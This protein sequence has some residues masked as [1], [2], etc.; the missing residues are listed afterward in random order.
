MKKFFPFLLT[1]VIFPLVAVDR[2][3]LDSPREVLIPCRQNRDWKIPA[4]Q[5]NGRVIVS[6]EHRLDFPRLGGWAPCWQIFV[7]DQP[8]SSMATRNH[9]RL[10]NKPRSASHLDHGTYK[11][12][13]GE[14]WYSLYSPDY[15][16][17]KKRF[18]PADP[19][20]YRVAL[21]ITGLLRRDRENVVKIRFGSE[22][23][24]YYKKMNVKCPPALGVRNFKVVQE[25]RPSPIPPVRKESEYVHLKNV[26]P[27]DYGLVLREK[28]LIVNFGKLSVPV[29]SYFSAPGAKWYEM[30]GE[31][32]L[33]TPFYAVMRKIVQQ[34]NRI[35]VFDT[36]ISKSDR[37]IGLKIR[38][39]IP[40]GNFDPVYLAG[41]PSP[42][43]EENAGGR[44]P[45]VFLSAPTLEQ[46]IALIAQDDVFRV[47]NLQYCKDGK[48]GIRTETFALSPG[49]SRTVE[50]SIYPVM[51]SD[52]FDFVN[53]VR[54]DWDVNFLIDGGF[55]LS[56]NVF[57]HWTPEEAR[58]FHRNA[59]LKYN[60]LGVFYWGHLGG[61]YA[62]R[63]CA[64]QGSSFID[65]E[66]RGSLAPNTI[67]NFKNEPMRQFVREMLAKAGAS[68]PELKRF[69]YVHNQWSTEVDD[70]RK[71][72]DC[73]VT[74]SNGTYRNRPPYHFFIPTTENAYGKKFM[75]FLRTLCEDY[76]PEGIY[77]DEFTYTNSTL[78]YN[79][80]DKVSVELNEKNEVVRKIGFV[81]L[82]KLD[83]N[84]R[85]ADYILNRKKKLLIA[86]FSPETRTERK[87]KFPRFE[88]TYYSNWVFLSHLYTPIQLGDMLTYSCTAE[89]C[90][91]DI[92]NALRNGT[93]YYHYNNQAACPTI[94][95]KMYPF[96]PVEIHRGWLLGKER[97]LT[98]RSGEFCWKGENALCIPY[99]YDERG[100]LIP[101]YP[102]V[103]S[104][105]DGETVCTLKLGR[106]YCAALVK[107]P[108][109]ALLGKTVCLESVSLEDGKLSAELVGKG[110]VRI[111]F[112]GQT[113]DFTSD[114]TKPVRISMWPLEVK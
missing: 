47:Q 84:M 75:E 91:A 13:I 80:W 100:A 78:T 57:Q 97:I 20:A 17:A 36:V 106:K 55:H 50:W 88:E 79:L 105:R 74:K 7:N 8:V 43:S 53:E 9:P 93:L 95:A 15:E 48:S 27:V 66:S 18:S 110:T 41:D 25:D 98:I 40:S 85:V 30:G 104:G 14:K 99:V 12:D 46:G 32:R 6:F 58:K 62:K 65:E 67:M 10:L 33:E 37:L 44:N 68:M 24:G 61:E 5:S 96:T 82:L 63:N 73:A 86:N 2:I 54:R 114:G 56:L 112:N 107:I 49:E 4:L 42:N 19:E 72:G 39:E 35:D 28:C 16:S 29:T 76:N 70:Y 111:I 11:T 23:S 26:P 81:P 90:A 21:D 94:T 22:L 1:A 77:H 3:L 108:V 64:V 34:K 113:E 51:S 60:A 31:S 89:D 83:F 87:F 69:I 59:G 45:S 109:R 101:G 71:Y 103:F 52:Y 92:R 102:A 38:Y